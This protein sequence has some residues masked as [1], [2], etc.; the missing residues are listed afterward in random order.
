MADNRLRSG[1]APLDAVLGGGL[2]ANGISVIMGLPG[3][4]KTIVA[5]QYAF[6]NATADRPVVYFSTVSEPLEKIIR[7]GQN[8]GFFDTAAVGTS[9]FYADLGQTVGRRRPAW[10]GRAGR[11]RA[12]RASARADRDRQLQGPAGVRGQRRRLP[13]I[14]APACRPADRLPGGLPVGRRVRRPSDIASLPEFAVADAIVDLATIRTDQ[15]DMRYLKVRKLRGGGFLSGGHAYRLGPDGLHLFPR[16][17]DV[18]TQESYLLGDQRITSG[19]ANL[20][21]MLD[22][23][24][25]PGA[26]TMVAGRPAQGRPCSA[27]TSSSAAWPAAS[28]VSSPPCRNI[29]A[30]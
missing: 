23:G 26:S 18:P 1:H 29:R 19:N 14:P 22:G 7:F 11:R 21:E 8:L 30:S 3:T 15:R 28:R 12:A 13:P 10:R 17:A 24:L 25:W 6:T 20:D 9:V 16:L 27:C 4:G 2:P 5:Q